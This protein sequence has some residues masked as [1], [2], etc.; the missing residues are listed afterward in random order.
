MQKILVVEDEP[1]IQE[2]LAAYLKNEGYEVVLAGDGIAA[3]GQFHAEEADLVL[4]DVLLP[5]IDGFSV[6]ELIRKESTVPII[7]LTALDGEAEQLKGFD[8]QIDDYVTKPF[9]MPV[10]LRKIAAILRRVNGNLEPERLCYRQLSLELDTRECILEK[11]RLD[12]TQKEF[13]LLLELIKMPGRVLTREVLLE[14]L[15]GYDFFGDERIV[16]SHIKNLRKKMNNDYIE[17]VRGV[18]YRVA[19]EN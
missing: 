3:I 12:L 17:T 5:K 16:D 8:L 2:F 1:E 4:L 15:W 11:Q 7:M 19:K 13:D 18:G 14:R 10:L 6:C 9:S